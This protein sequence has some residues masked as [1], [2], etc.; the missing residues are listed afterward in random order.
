MQFEGAV[1]REQGITFAVVI[2]RKAVIDF[3]QQA[4]RAIRTFSGAFGA[5]QQ[6]FVAPQAWRSRGATRA[7]RR[8]S[9]GSVTVEL[10]SSSRGAVTVGFRRRSP[11]WRGANA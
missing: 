6:T 4:D 10:S 9:K 2:V 11:R 7:Y 5:R 8:A 1:I 3:R